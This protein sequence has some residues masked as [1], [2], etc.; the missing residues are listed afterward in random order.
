MSR[1]QHS[2]YYESDDY[3]LERNIKPHWYKI[4]GNE[5]EYSVRTKF[6]EK[7]Y[8][9]KYYIYSPE[10]DAIRNEYG[11]YDGLYMYTGNPVFVYKENIKTHINKKGLLY[12]YFLAI[13]KKLRFATLTSL[14]S[15]LLIDQRSINKNYS[16]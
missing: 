2:N 3:K 1:K 12:S 8:L 9:R 11:Y 16:V 7:G 13:A 4:Y 14:R 5:I 15:F 10:L 6:P